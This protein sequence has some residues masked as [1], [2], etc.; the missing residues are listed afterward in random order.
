MNTS[1]DS[2]SIEIQSVARDSSKAV[3][4][5]IA[6]LDQLRT[7]LQ[8]VIKES[9]SFSQLKNNLEVA[10]KTATAR[11]SSANKGFISAQAAATD[12]GAIGDLGDSSYAKLQSTITRTNSE[13]Q[14]FILNNNNVLTITKRTKNGVDDY[15]ASMRKLGEES[16]N[17]S[18]KL[19]SLKNSFLKTSATI[20]AGVLVIKKLAN[21][22]STY[23]REAANYEEAMN[24]FMV[25]M[26]DNAENASKWVE[27]FSNALYL[28]PASVMQYMG[29]FNALTKGLGVGADKAYIMSQNLTQLTYDLA[30]FKNLDF[31]TAFRKLQSAISGEIEPLRNVGVALSQATLQE[32]A[33]SLGI[34]Q[35]VAEMSEAQKAQLRYIQIMRSTTEW[36]TDMGRTLVTP[37]NALRILKQQFTLL[38]RAIGS[39]FIPI[40][41]SAVP[42]IMVITQA[43]TKLAQRLADLLGYKIQDVDYSRISTGLSGISD[44]IEDIGDEAGKAAKKLN[45]MLAPFDELNVVQNKVEST[46]KGL[47]DDS[48]GGD[49]GIPLPEYDALAN[50]NDKFAKNMDKAREKLKGILAIVG[51]IGGAFATWKISKKLLEG[52]GAIEKLTPKNLSFSVSIIGIANFLSDI[53]E[54]RKWLDDILDNG[55]TFRNVTGILSEFAGGIGDVFTILGRTKLGGSLKVIQGIGEITSAISDI[56]K[57]GINWDNANDAIRGLTNIAIGVGLFTGKLRFVG[58]VTAIQGFT[59]IIEELHKNWDAIKK[60]DWSGVDKATL[61]IGAVQVLG[62]VLVAFDTFNKIKKTTDIK[63][64]ATNMSELSTATSKT[65]S[66]LKDL[67]KNLGFGILIIG[68]I[69]VAAGLFVGAIWVLGK[70]L[71]QVGIAWD[72]VLKNGP[73]IAKAIG[74]GTGLL[75]AIGLATALLGKATTSTGGSLPLSIALGTAILIE[76]GVATALFIAEVWAIGKGLD[77]IRIAWQ[78]VLDN[79]ETVRSGIAI[80]TSIL[81]AIGVATAA[82]GAATVASAGTLPI[83]IGLGTAMLVELGAAT[84]KFID[85]ISKIAKQLNDQLT[86]QLARINENSNTVT[87]GLENYTDFLKRFATIIYNTTK[88]NVLASFSSFVTTLIG[89]FS[90]NPIEKLAKDVN[91]TYSQSRDLNYKL[92]QANPELQTVISLLSD[93]LKLIKRLDSLTSGNKIS[94]ISGNIFVNMKDAGKQLVNGFVDGMNSRRGSLDGA[95]N[96]IYNAFN[97]SRATQIGRSFG[98]SIANGINAGIKSNISSTI[99]LSDKSGKTAN[100]FTVKAYAEGG[101]PRYGEFFVANENGPEMIGKIGNRSAV[102]NND[103]IETSLTNALITALNNYNFGGNNGPTTIYIGNKKVY[104]GY[105]DYVNSENDRYGTNTIRI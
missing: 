93:Y 78:P 26:G 90:K 101:Y 4:T 36:Q 74:L 58:A 81:I 66:S 2:L 7:S 91:K 18:S 97:N 72:P 22:M 64:T 55:P 84:E 50:L 3:D 65:T 57:N 95:V 82:L 56:A 1:M 21:T 23:V 102:A 6:K 92:S 44:G 42:Y 14:R 98:Q 10:S 9:N 53:N 88:V 100:Q 38:A 51:S 77:Q 67:A 45:T 12:V 104:E 99:K 31:D 87:R 39:V 76:L 5:L 46:K 43:L 96:N 52:L 24:L 30:S 69:A 89:W 48:L 86:P 103:Q 33:Y 40:L 71:E 62:G 15:T 17:T 13:T 83:A 20:T 85:S 70:E 35:N 49:L 68:E 37:A 94:N 79:G 105:G 16:N 25:T 11:S 27:K 60:G 34:E 59:S 63:D 29:S 32:L 28:D 41:M 19:G 75:V 61:M 47:G 8:N 54:L 80:G 73:T